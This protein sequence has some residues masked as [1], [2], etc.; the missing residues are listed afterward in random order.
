ML[1][2]PRLIF[3][4]FLGLLIGLPTLFMNWSLVDDGVIIMKAKQI[5]ELISNLNFTGFFEFFLERD[6]GRFRPIYYLTYWFIYLIGGANV[7]IFYLFHLLVFVVIVWLLYRISVSL[8]NKDAGFWAVFFFLVTALNVENWYRLGPQEPFVVLFFLLSLYFFSK[9]FTKKSTSFWPRLAS[10]VFV[11]CAYFT[12]E[13]SVAF[14]LSLGTLFFLFLFLKIK[15]KTVSQ[16]YDGSFLA[17]YFLFNLLLALIVFLI[18]NSLRTQGAY[19]VNYTLAKEMLIPSLISYFKVIFN[20]FFPVSLLIL[21]ACVPLY[22][23][24]LLR[25]LVAKEV[26]FKELWS[27]FFLFWFSSFLFF[28]LPWKFV[29]AR[30]LMPSL[31]GLVIFMAFIMSEIENW[32]KDSLIRGAL[33][34]GVVFLLIFHNLPLIF[35]TIHGSIVGSNAAEG[36]L[37]YVAQVAPKDSTVYFNFA[38]SDATLELFVESELHFRH[39]LNRPDLKVAYLERESSL[40]SGTRIV[41][42]FVSDNFLAYSDDQLEDNKYF[43]KEKEF[44]YTFVTLSGITTN[45]I[46][47]WILYNVPIKIFSEKRVE[48][49]ETDWKI[50]SKI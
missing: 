12:K 15:N 20:S 38:K 14:L 10:Y 29:L 9:V 34:S 23:N 33:V 24:K 4:F 17:N 32:L 30:Y 16:K 19:T 28:Q 47:N 1:S 35:N 5:S 22:I 48:K 44:K 11:F 18:S 36:V 42:A 45:E 40:S 31:V 49:R 43:Q 3:L 37:K 39:F 2:N 21:I 46:K 7:F 13:T 25:R 27:I 6:I 50:F 8:V 26:P 41:S